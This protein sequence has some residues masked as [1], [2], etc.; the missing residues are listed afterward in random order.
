MRSSV[1]VH[2]KKARYRKQIDDCVNN[3]SKLYKELNKLL[4]MNFDNSVFPEYISQKKLAMDFRDFLM[5]K[6]HNIIDNFDGIAEIPTFF[7]I[8]DFPLSVISK[9]SV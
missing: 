3:S 2:H 6:M 4:E 5:S 8:P 1:Y 7:L 9:W